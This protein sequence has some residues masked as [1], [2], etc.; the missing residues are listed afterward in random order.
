MIVHD[1]VREVLPVERESHGLRCATPSWRVGSLSSS[2]MFKAPYLSSMKECTRYCIVKEA[3]HE[4]EISSHV[5]SQFRRVPIVPS[6]RAFSMCAASRVRGRIAYPEGSPA[7]DS[8]CGDSG[9]F[10]QGSVD[11]VP[12]L[13]CT[14]IST[15]R[16]RVRARRRRVRAARAHVRKRLPHDYGITLQCQR[17]MFYSH[18][19]ACSALYSL[20]SSFTSPGSPL[21][22]YTET[23]SSSASSPASPSTLRHHAR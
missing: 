9:K 12:V 11:T 6:A 13:S 2:A 3:T 4:T 10:R 1:N 19:E 7:Y 23:I 20:A 18:D 14:N 16:P 21:A 17:S 5:N 8:S 22:S 15:S